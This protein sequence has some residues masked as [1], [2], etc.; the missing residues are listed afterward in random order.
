[1]QKRWTLKPSDDPEKLDQLASSLNIRRPLA[2][3]LF[4]REVFDFDAAKTFF[5]PQLD[6]L[7]DPFQMK[8]MDKAVQRLNQ[9]FENQ[10]YVLIY[11]DYD[12]DGTTSVALLYLFLSQHYD[13]L[14]FYVPDRYAEGYGVSKAGVDYA[15]DNDIKLIVALDCG[16]KANETIS[17]AKELGIDFI[18]CDHHLPGDELPPATAILDPKQADCHY[19]FKE[20]SGCGIGFKFLQAWCRDQE[21]SEGSLIE[22]I[23]LTAISIACDIVPIVG[24]NRVLAYYG[25]LRI[26]NNPRPGVVALLDNRASKKVL[27]ITDLVFGIGPRINAAGRIEHAKK[28]VELLISQDPNM[29]LDKGKYISDQNDSRK[30]IDQEIT[31]QALAMVEE[32]DA[33]LTAK[34]TVLYREDWHKGVIGIVASRVQETYYR[35]TILLTKSNGKVTGS[36]RSVKGFNIYNAIESCSELL[37]QF[38]GHKY[39]AGLTLDEKNIAAFADRFEVQVR[40]NITEEQLVPE[41]LIDLELDFADISG[42]FFRI[43]QQ[44]SPFGPGNMRPLFVT[45]NVVDSGYSRPVG[46]DG[47]HLKLSVLQPENPDRRMDGIGFSM[48]HLHEEISNKRPFDLVYTVEENE[49]NGEINLQ[50]KVKDIRF[51]E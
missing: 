3:L 19:P 40:E 45:R 51:K 18:V 13:F 5:R 34:S 9:A 2:Q 15:H 4:H 12:V 24:E 35:P 49:W 20:L 36:A 1:M 30:E 50:L 46:S 31:R 22:L 21:F 41:L 32:N 28:A 27:T 10:E 26:N 11:G 6:Q 16:I 29:A 17:Y 47:T 48:G 8:D 23:D 38:G 44:L 37:E 33:L 43:V 39:A 25:M 42:K 14:D 7:H